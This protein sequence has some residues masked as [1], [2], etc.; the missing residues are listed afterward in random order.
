MVIIK[1]PCLSGR[2]EKLKVN[3]STT[4]RIDGERSRTIKSKKSEKWEVGYA[5]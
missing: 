4:L 5:F 1:S 3:P 2:Q